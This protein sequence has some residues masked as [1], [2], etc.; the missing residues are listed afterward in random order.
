ML[1]GR[2]EPPFS[3]LCFACG[4]R[5]ENQTICSCTLKCS[6]RYFT[7]LIRNCAPFEASCGWVR[8]AVGVATLFKVTSSIPHIPLKLHA[9]KSYKTI[10]HLQT[11]VEADGQEDIG[12]PP[13]LFTVKGTHNHKYTA[14][15][16][17]NPSKHIM[18]KSDCAAF[19]QICDRFKLGLGSGPC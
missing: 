17:P 15:V 2:F 5:A 7:P 1:I 3:L 18:M 9:N 8:S 19:D 14:W 16:F 4:R 12:G 11:P 10:R 6:W 13:I